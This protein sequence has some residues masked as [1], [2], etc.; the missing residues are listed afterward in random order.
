MNRVAYLL[1]TL[2]MFWFPAAAADNNNDPANLLEL[3]SEAERAYRERDAAYAQALFLELTELYPGDPEM[4]FGLSR[5]YEWAGEL[6]KSIAA[7]ERVQSLGFSSRSFLSYRLARLNALANHTDAALDWLEHALE[8]GFEE[9]PQIRSDEAFVGL[10]ENPRFIELAGMPP[11]QWT[12]RTD[13]LRFDIE[14]LVEEAQRMHAALDRPAWSAHFLAEAAALQKSIPELSDAE[15]LISIM[16]LVAI[17]SDGHSAIYGIDPDSPLQVSRNVLPLKFFAFAEGVYVV[18]GIGAAAD[19]AG[20]RVLRFGSLSAEE[21]LDRLSKYR[22]TDNPMTWKWMGPQFYL[23]RMHLLQAIGATES[24]DRITLALEDRSGNA[25]TEELEAGEY[26]I[27]R[28]LRPSAAATGDVPLYLRNVDIEHWMESLPE[29]QAIYFQFNQVRDGK[30]QSIAEFASL[31]G[32]RLKKEN[33]STLIVDVRHNNGGNNS[34]LRPLIRTMVA[35]ELASPQNQIYVITGRN[36]FSAAQNF[37]SRVEQWTDAIFVGEPSAASPN[38][39]GE[40]TSLLLPYSR[41]RGSISTRYWQDSNPG[42]D[43]QWIVPEVPIPPT[44]ADY[45]LGR[46]AVMEAIADLITAAQDR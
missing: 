39:V 9:R 36:T 1:A 29:Q 23:G 43:R 13:G 33:A 5:A 19:F 4:W 18:D 44:A 24:T 8:E 11:A 26:S 40:E 3:R 30:D 15:V 7:A 21:T 2:L 16:R 12:G 34:L 38:F 17:L 28:K 31:L 14:Y 46:D 45:F 42:D 41:V 35:F 22:G 20:N 37:V 32:E 6:N 27:Q 25:F 10:R